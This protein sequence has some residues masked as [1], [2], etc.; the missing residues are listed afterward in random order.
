MREQRY[1]P[2]GLYLAALFSIAFWIAIIF[3]L[4]FFLAGCVPLA[5]YHYATHNVADEAQQSDCERDSQY[6]KKHKGGL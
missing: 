2:T 6:C 3:T 1:Y 4:W 5:L